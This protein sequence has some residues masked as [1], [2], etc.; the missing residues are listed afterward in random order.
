MR[1]KAA[2]EAFAFVGKHWLFEGG[3]K[4]VPC[5]FCVGERCDFAGFVEICKVEHAWFDLNTVSVGLVGKLATE[6]IEK[7]GHAVL[8]VKDFEILGVD[9]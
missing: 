2:D 6:G 9:V 3:F 5:V 8:D 1:D 4:F 7:G